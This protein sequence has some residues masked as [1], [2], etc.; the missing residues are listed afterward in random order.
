MAASHKIG[1]KDETRGFFTGNKIWFQGGQSK[2][3][4]PE[5]Y[6]ARGYYA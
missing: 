1:E 4:K 3:K 2:S 5:V 6:F